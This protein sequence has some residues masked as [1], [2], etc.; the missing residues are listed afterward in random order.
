MSYDKLPIE[1]KNMIFAQL[2]NIYQ[3][4]ANCIQRY[5]RKFTYP[6]KIALSLWSKFETNNPEA[7]GASNFITGYAGDPYLMYPITVKLTQFSCKVLKLKKNPETIR[8][9][10]YIL[11]CL[12]ISLWI[13][14]YSGGSRGYIHEKIYDNFVLM[15]KK[16]DITLDKDGY[17][18]VVNIY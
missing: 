11:Y 3:K 17:I 18:K 12:N 2:H 9:W 1:I 5:W 6:E 10:K 7:W 4:N 8:L 14:E 13:E 15:C 16:L